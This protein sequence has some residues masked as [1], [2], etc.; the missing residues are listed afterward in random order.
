MLDGGAYTDGADWTRPRPFG[1]ILPLEAGARGDDDDGFQRGPHLPQLRRDDGRRVV[2]CLRAEACH[3]A[4]SA[5]SAI[6]LALAL[7]YVRQRRYF[8]AHFVVA[9]H[10]FTFLL[11]FVQLVVT[12]MHWLPEGTGLAL[13]PWFF[14]TVAVAL[15]GALC[16]YFLLACRTA[17]RIGW[18]GGALGLVAVLAGLW[19]ANLWVYRALQFL[20]TLALLD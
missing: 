17:Y 15:L 2:P 7:V 19:F 14:A 1:S 6:A 18:V 10:L 20:V 9:L 13:P 16:A 12:P 3:R 8:A 11:L 4:L 5:A